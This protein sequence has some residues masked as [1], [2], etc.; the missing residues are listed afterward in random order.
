MIHAFVLIDAQPDAITD[1]SMAIV[2]LD[3]VRETHSV[4]GGEC[5][6]VAVLAVADHESI[7]RVVTDGSA[8]LEGVAGTRTM[9]AFRSYSAS[10]LDA[11]YEG[12]GD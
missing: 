8:K 3:G 6:L 1:L 2:E 9:I 10:D 7:A 4:A 11:G 12:F 5:D